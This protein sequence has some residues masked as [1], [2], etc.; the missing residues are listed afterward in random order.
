V[1]L[2]VGNA[3]GNVLVSYAMKLSPISFNIKTLYGG[4]GQLVIGMQSCPITEAI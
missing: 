3:R 4:N 2:P 1:D